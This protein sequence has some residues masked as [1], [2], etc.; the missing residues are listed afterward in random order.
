MILTGDE[1]PTNRSEVFSRNVSV[2]IY[3]GLL[4]FCKL[5]L[6]AAIII[7]GDS[8]ISSSFSVGPWGYN[9]SQIITFIIRGDW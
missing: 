7:W 3:G 6:S 9:M 5:A 4:Y 1:A 8:K 2:R